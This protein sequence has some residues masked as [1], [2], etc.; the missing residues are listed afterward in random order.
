MQRPKVGALRHTVDCGLGSPSRNTSI[1]LF[2]EILNY[3]VFASN[4][5]KARPKVRALRH[6]VD[7]GLGSPE[8]EPSA[9]VFPAS[10]TAQLVSRAHCPPPE[11]YYRM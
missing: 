9:A 4:N 2:H 5:T 6:T 3:L 8:A 7:C 10:S 1:W 11:P